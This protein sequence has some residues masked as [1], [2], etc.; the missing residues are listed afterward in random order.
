MYT[1]SSKYFKLNTVILYRSSLARRAFYS[2]Y[3]LRSARISFECMLF[4]R[5]LYNICR[6]ILFC[7]T[8]YEVLRYKMQQSKMDKRFFCD[9]NFARYTL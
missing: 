9:P 3:P 6:C 4:G 7:A 5:T 2:V 8:K 1:I